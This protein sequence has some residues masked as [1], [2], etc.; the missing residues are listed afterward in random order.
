MPP[1]ELR[2]PRREALL[3]VRAV[4]VAPVV[5]VVPA[6]AVVPMV[7]GRLTLR[8]GVGGTGVEQLRDAFPHLTV[9]PAFCRGAPPSPVVWS[10][11]SRHVLWR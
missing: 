6:V 5:M 7:S 1:L 8:L 3:V 4:A 9:V 10:S 2:R 11:Q